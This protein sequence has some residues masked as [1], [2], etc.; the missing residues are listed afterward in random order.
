[1]SNQNNTP[2]TFSK[3]EINILI[4]AKPRHLALE[5]NLP[6]RPNSLYFRTI[7]NQEAYLV[8]MFYGP[9]FTVEIANPGE[10]VFKPLFECANLNE[11][12]HTLRGEDPR[13]GRD[14][15]VF[16]AK[17][18]HL[19]ENS[20]E[21]APAAFFAEHVLGEADPTSSTGQKARRWINEMLAEGKIGSRPGVKADSTKGKA[22]VEFFGTSAKA[23]A[24][25]EAQ[26]NLR[27]EREANRAKLIEDLRSLVGDN[28]Q[29]RNGG[30][31]VTLDLSA[32]EF[33]VSAL[34]P[35]TE[36]VNELATI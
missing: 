24:F 8:S 18:L 14:K 11:V 15:P 7:D 33:L 12:I 35:E 22:P 21:S 31:S 27:A 5:G 2:V 32:V 9:R 13:Q 36:E 1:M 29:V 17:V 3:N 20:R 10:T 30:D 4:G 28:G 16:E 6:S 25:S 26:A 19:L 34:C 23:I